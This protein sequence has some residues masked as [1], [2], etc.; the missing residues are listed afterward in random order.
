MDMKEKDITLEDR[1]LIQ[2]KLN[3]FIKQEIDR[4]TAE[5]NTKIFQREILSTKKIK[6]LQ[7]T[8]GDMTFTFENPKEALPEIEKTIQRIDKIISPL[9]IKERQSKEHGKRLKKEYYDKTGKVFGK[10]SSGIGEKTK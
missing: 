10:P 9:K 6:E 4:W 7:W 3:K 1:I 5:I 8:I 2:E